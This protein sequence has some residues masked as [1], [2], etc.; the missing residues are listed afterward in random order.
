MNVEFTQTTDEEDK[1]ALIS[2]Y[3]A[4]LLDQPHMAHIFSRSEN[5]LECVAL[6]PSC[7]YSDNKWFFVWLSSKSDGAYVSNNKYRSAEDA[8]A[9]L[10]IGEWKHQPNAKMVLDG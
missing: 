7:K 5:D 8:A 2:K 4:L 6:V 3:T 9:I 10:A 1:Q